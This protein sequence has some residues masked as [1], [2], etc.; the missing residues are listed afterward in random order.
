MCEQ[1]QTAVPAKEGIEL[2]L[3]KV[4]AITPDTENFGD[5]IG[6]CGLNACISVV[7]TLQFLLDKD[8][9]NIFYIGTALT[10]TIDLKVQKSIVL[11]DEEIDEHPLMQEARMFLL[12]QT[13]KNR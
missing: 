4:E 8:P 10:D 5:E 9:L 13:S 12:E 3:S 2:M 7:Y 6:S 11:S 1:A